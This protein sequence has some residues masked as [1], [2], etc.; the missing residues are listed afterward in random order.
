MTSVLDVL[1]ASVPFPGHTTPLLPIARALTERG[2]RV[3]WCAGRRFAGQ[4]EAAG[5][6]FVAL[7]EAIDLSRGTVDELFPERARV[8]GLAKLRFDMV[9]VFIDPVPAQVAALRRAHGERA[10][11]VVVHDVGFGG[12]GAFGALA[13]VPNVSVGVTPLMLAGPHTAPFGPG[14]QPGTGPLARLRNRALQALFDRVVL[15]EVHARAVAVQRELGL[16]PVRGLS[17]VSRHLHLQNGLASLEHPR[18]DLPARVRFV[19]ALLPPA[20][21]GDLPGWW[22]DVETADRPVV[23]VTQG[24]V[25]DG[26]LEDLVLPA[27]RA[28]AD[29]DVLVVA[30]T[31]AHRP[32]HVPANA[33]LASFLPYDR[34][35]PRLSVMVTNGGFGGVQNALAHGV[36]L[37]VGGA[38]EDKPEVAARVARAGVGIDL[39]TGRPKPEAIR[40]AVR[41]V[42]DVPSFRDR[43]AAM[44]AEYAAH[45]APGTSADLIEGVV[46]RATSER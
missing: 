22:G 16:P 40:D 37:V 43:A 20:S 5:A 26:D 34:L 21:S 25:A 10:A 32:A 13:G 46:R 38:T 44:A 41:R 8:T 42:L 17:G 14:L 19:G 3:R 6:E 29:E 24:T 7:D 23:H 39:R 36:P 15:R 30:S 4:V 18:P 45:D 28:L 12:G 35:L 31:G 9:S 27:L 11:D 1:F 33:R 2:H